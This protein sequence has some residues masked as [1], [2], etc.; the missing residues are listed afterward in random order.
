MTQPADPERAASSV[1]VTAALEH[2]EKL[3]ASGDRWAARTHVVDSLRAT[4]DRAPLLAFLD[5]HFPLAREAQ[6]RLERLRD[7]AA[8]VE[9]RLACVR[10][11]EAF[12]D[13]R[14]V[15]PLER[16]RDEL[17]KPAPDRG[18]YW[19]LLERLRPLSDLLRTPA[20]APAPTPLA[21]PGSSPAHDQDEDDDEPDAGEIVIPELGDTW[22]VVGT[23]GVDAGMAGVVPLGRGER[24]RTPTGVGDGTWDVEACRGARPGAVDVRVV[25]DKALA[26][27]R[28]WSRGISRSADGYYAVEDPIVSA[29]IGLGVAKRALGQASLAVVDGVVVV[30]ATS[31][32]LWIRGKKDSPGI[33]R[34]SFGR[35]ADG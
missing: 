12:H 24:L 1:L 18:A 23:L 8:T 31:A 34:V 21:R 4:S 15:E 2:A 10:E 26:T 28:E 33:M 32:A 35:K 6:A 5:R 27:G 14:F 7:P 22:R 11:V 19:F 17:D 13:P 25:F 29:P 9:A 3:L 30:R 16:L 20:V